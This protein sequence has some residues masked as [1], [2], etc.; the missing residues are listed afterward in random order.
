M[1]NENPTEEVYQIDGDSYD[2]NSDDNLVETTEEDGAYDIEVFLPSSRF[3][4]AL[5]WE[6]V[7]ICVCLV[8]TSGAVW[9]WENIKKGI[10]F[11]FMLI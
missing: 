7:Y 8:G 2:Q 1:T 3:H 5:D 9:R 6:G 11:Y 10:C 4:P